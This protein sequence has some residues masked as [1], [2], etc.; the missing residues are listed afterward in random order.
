LRR[1]LKQQKIRI[2]TTTAAIT[3][4]TDTTMIT[5]II[6]LL[7]FVPDGDG[8]GDWL[9]MGSG[10]PAFGAG[11]AGVGGEVGLLP[12]VQGSTVSCRFPLNAASP[13]RQ[14]TFLV[15][16][17]MK[18]LLAKFKEVRFGCRNRD[19][20]MSPPR[21]FDEQSSDSK[22]GLFHTFGSSP[23]KKLSETFNVERDWDDAMDTGRDPVSWFPFSRTVCRDDW[24]GISKSLGMG[25][26]RELLANEKVLREDILENTPAGVCPWIWL[27]AML[28]TSNF[29]IHF[30]HSGMEPPLEPP[31]WLLS[32][33]KRFSWIKA[34]SWEGTGPLM[35]FPDKSS[36]LRDTNL[37]RLLE[38]CPPKPAF[39]RRTACTYG[40]WKF[41]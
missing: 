10:F 4:K 12:P 17:P 26:V 25:P 1:L 3:A 31:S 36:Q 7:C 9:V 11:V 32:R 19:S 20:G 6:M 29:D 30:N 41:E 16:V 27:L 2:A 34:L 18:L 40:I 35:L 24:I 39:G 37:P 38:N 21:L 14:E 33:F 28:N 23:V 22:R 5:M 8:A 15:T 13:K